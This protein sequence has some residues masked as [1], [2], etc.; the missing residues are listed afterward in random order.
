VPCGPA[1]CGTIVWTK[2]DRKDVNNPDPA[3][4][5]SSLVG[6]QMIRGALPAGAGWT[7]D[8]YNPLDGRTYKGRM[9]LISA[10]E[11]ELSGCV[12]A[13]LICRGQVWTRVR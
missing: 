2:A 6:L 11:L 9:R 12:L 7:G 10:S 4:R 5:T 8:L 13:G 3:R 1:R